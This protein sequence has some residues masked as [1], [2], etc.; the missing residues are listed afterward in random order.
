[1]SAYDTAYVAGVERV[2]VMLASCDERDLVSRGLA[3]LPRE[4]LASGPSST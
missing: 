3:K 1:L 4:L 2:S